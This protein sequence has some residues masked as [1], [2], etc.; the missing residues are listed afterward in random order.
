MEDILNATL[1]GGVIIGAPSG[2]FT[3][4]AGSLCIGIFA[5]VVSCLGYRYLQAKLQD[6][7]GLHDS[8]G[9]HNL[10]GMPGILGGIFSAIAIASYSS[11]PLTDTT[12]ISYLPFYPN[13][14]TQRNAHGRTFL[15]QGG[16]QIAA[17]FI[18]MGIGIVFGIIAGLLM[19]IVYVF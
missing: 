17:I 16:C 4:P 2:I 8:C 5:G 7:I 14:F 19:K 11:D 1:A 18:S 13:P 9:V 10:H 15:D 12:Q 3:N 6:W